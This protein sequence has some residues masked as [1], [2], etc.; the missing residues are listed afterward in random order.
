MALRTDS[1][2][3]SNTKATAMGK[4]WMDEF[5][6]IWLIVGPFEKKFSDPKHVASVLCGQADV[7]A[8]EDL[9][10]RELLVEFIEMTKNCLGISSTDMQRAVDDHYLEV[11]RHPK[12]YQQLEKYIRSLEKAIIKCIRELED[13]QRGSVE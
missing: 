8:E 12:L 4:R 3:Q 7:S 9:A 10:M 13:A 6:R 11:A 1:D 2:S 5:R